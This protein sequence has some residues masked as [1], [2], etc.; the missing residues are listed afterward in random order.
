MLGYVVFVLYLLN[1]D[2]RQRFLTTIPLGQFN[3][4]TKINIK[5][6]AEQNH[7][8]AMLYLGVVCQHGFGGLEKNPTLAHFWYAKA[9]TEYSKKAKL[10]DPN[11]MFKLGGAFHQGVGVEQDE[12]K[13]VEWLLKAVQKDHTAATARLAFCY[14]TGKGLAKNLG[15]A[16]ACY[17]IAA[18]KVLY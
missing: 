10:G 6:A 9:A 14:A 16:V 7:D 1:N 11:A 8:D 4:Q 3:L 5:Q 2:Y 12:A 17:R 18:D 13:G 15:R